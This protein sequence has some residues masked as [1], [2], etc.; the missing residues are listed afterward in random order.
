M[1]SE[2]AKRQDGF[3]NRTRRGKALELSVR[4]EVCMSPVVLRHVGVEL[5]LLCGFQDLATV[6]F[7]LDT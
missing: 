1:L 5:H 6:L 3:L 2:T 7:V 4:L